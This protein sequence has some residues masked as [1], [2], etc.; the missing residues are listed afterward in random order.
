M[1][2]P[3]DSHEG[4]GNA[5]CPSQRLERARPESLVWRSS[6]ISLP[7]TGPVGRLSN[8]LRPGGYRLDWVIL[9]RRRPTTDRPFVV[10]I[11]P[12]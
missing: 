5:N 9:P 10:R 4:G 1:Q 3:A 7:T 12:G 8:F 6:S 2:E 11:I